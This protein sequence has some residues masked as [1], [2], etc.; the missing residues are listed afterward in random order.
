MFPSFPVDAAGAAD[1][2]TVK[3]AEWG[4]QTRRIDEGLDF[5]D[6][7]ELD[8]P[9]TEYY[10]SWDPYVSNTGTNPNPEYYSNH[11]GMGMYI[12]V[13]MMHHSLRGTQNYSPD[14]C[15]RAR[16]GIYPTTRGKDYQAA[17][18]SLPAIELH[19]GAQKKITA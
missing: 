2:V 18:Y 17:Y 11:N 10:W 12:T 3:A 19:Q 6:S 14:K 9:G 1:Q 4:Q 8:A 5:H 15:K 13:G 16:E 7:E